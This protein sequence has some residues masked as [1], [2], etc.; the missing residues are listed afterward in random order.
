M[1]QRGHGVPLVGKEGPA[2]AE[3]NAAEEASARRYRRSSTTQMLPR[4]VNRS[5]CNDNIWRAVTEAATNHTRKDMRKEERRAAPRRGGGGA[6]AALLRRGGGDRCDGRRLRRDEWICGMPCNE[7]GARGDG[8]GA[9]A[10][11]AGEGAEKG[12]PAA[13]AAAS[14]AGAGAAGQLTGRCCRFAAQ[15]LCSGRVAAE[16]SGRVVAA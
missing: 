13:G 1:D 10:S 4:N 6:G 7:D 12:A 15:L 14:A 3:R 8:A 5:R 2:G 11:A 9:P 16:S